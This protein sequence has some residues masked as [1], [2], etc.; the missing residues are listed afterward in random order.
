MIEIDHYDR[1]V[2]VSSNR[3]PSSITN[4]ELGFISDKVL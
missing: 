2:M 3:I 1:Y 4:Y